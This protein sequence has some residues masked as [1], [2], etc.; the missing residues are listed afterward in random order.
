MVLLSLL[1]RS[2][3]L[4]TNYPK[5]RATGCSKNGNACRE[6]Y[7]DTHLH[8]CTVHAHVL[9]SRAVCMHARMQVYTN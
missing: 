3:L 6:Q 2:S 4:C 5:V 7:G 8:T 1:V 9:S